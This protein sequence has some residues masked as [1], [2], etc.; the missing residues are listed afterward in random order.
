M[1][2]RP[3]AIRATA[4][5]ILRVT[6]VSPRRGDSW[7]KRIPLTAEHVVGLAVVDGRPVGGDLGDAVG[8]ARVEGRLLVLGRRRGAEHL[9]GGGLV[10]ARAHPGLADRL[11]QPH[12]PRAG[13]VEGVLGDIEG[14]A[15]VALRAE[16][17]DLIRLELVE[18][19]DQ[20]DGVGEVAV[21]GE[22]PHSL[23]VWVAVEMVDPVRV[24]ARGAADDAVDLVALLQ[25]QL[26]QVAAVLA[27]DSGDQGAL[28]GPR[29]AGQV[30]VSVLGLG[31]AHRGEA[32]ES[33]QGFCTAAFTRTRSDL[34]SPSDGCRN[35]GKL[36]PGR[37]R[38]GGVRRG[39]R[40]RAVGRLESARS[41]RL[42][43][44]QH[45]ARRSCSSPS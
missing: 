15:H 45:R 41:P 20:R 42:S 44:S 36:G 34:T 33:S 2:W 35:Q 3:A 22:Q 23:L 28:V 7:L 30:R 31:V 29:D 10:E 19:L 17:V 37:L 9:R 43:R 32:S 16:V 26:R 24:E 4:R 11:E 14:D 18:Q 5:V 25:Q 21:V 13:D 40:L 12:R 6:K 39:H 27:G 1:S 38:A 8:A